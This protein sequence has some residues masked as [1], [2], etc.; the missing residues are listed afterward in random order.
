MPDA[1]CQ[2]PDARRQMPDAR[3]CLYVFIDSAHILIWRLDDKD[4]MLTHSINCETN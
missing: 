4:F 2:T 1:R 3:I